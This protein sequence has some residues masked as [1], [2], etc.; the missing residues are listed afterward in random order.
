MTGQD[1]R[2]AL[3]T[4]M[5]W[6]IPE[7]AD[8]WD[9]ADAILAA[10][11]RRSTP[12]VVETVEELDALPNGTIVKSSAGTV[13]CRH[14]EFF[15]VVFGDER[16]FRWDLLALPATVLTPAPAPADRHKV[17]AAV[18]VGIRKR[19]EWPS[20]HWGVEDVHPDAWPHIAV[21]AAGAALDAIEGVRHG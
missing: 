15:G 5:G 9:I 18:L 17:E 2:E 13:A 1:E 8:A 12:H 11:F 16:P 10:G 21:A 6:R 7:S 3:V 4:V 19:L 14:S 20:L